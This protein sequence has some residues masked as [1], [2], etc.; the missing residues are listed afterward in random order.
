[1]VTNFIVEHNHI[2]H[3]S[4]IVHMMSSQR[5]MSAIQSVEIDL[6]YESGI[7]L[8][9][10]YQLMSKQVS[11]NDNLGFTKQDRKNYL[12]NK[13]QRALKFGEATSLKRYFCHQLK[14]SPSYYY[15]FQFNAKELITNIFWA[16][17]KIIIEYNHFRNVII[18]DTTYSTNRDVRPLGIF[19]GLNHHRDIVVFGTT[20]LYDKIIESFVWLFEIF[21][22]TMF[23]KRPITIFTNQDAAMAIAIQ[24]VMPNAYHALCSWHTWENANRYLG[25]LLKGGS[26]FNKDFLACIYEYDDEDEFLSAWAMILEKYDACENKWLISIFQLKEKW[27]QAYVKRMFTAGMKS[28]QLSKRFNCDLND[29]LQTNLNILEFF[30]HFERVAK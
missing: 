30:T 7:R 14:E 25:Y 4:T 17:A 27:A 16:N 6:A 2:L 29:C 12:C 23:E 24:E 5:R 11:G 9:D 8:K 1:M 15:A 20:L 26:R 3:L 21:L 18:F 28:T 19:L 22:E 13:R 10:S